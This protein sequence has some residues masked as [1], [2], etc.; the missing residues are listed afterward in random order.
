MLQLI[1]RTL[2][3]VTIENGEMEDNLRLENTNSKSVDF[4]RVSWSLF[5]VFVYAIAK[6]LSRQLF[7][8]F[9]RIF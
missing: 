6:R 3:K 1:N 7:C 5:Y 4:N 8:I 2:R 9:T